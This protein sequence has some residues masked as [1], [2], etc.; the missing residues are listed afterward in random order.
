M[1]AD[2]L[3]TAHALAV[4]APYDYHTKQ[5]WRAKGMA[6]LRR[7]AKDL[8]L[9][10]GTYDLRFN[11]GGGAVSGD[12]ILH[13][14]SLYVHLSG[15]SAGDVGYTRRVKGRKDYFG[16]RNISVPKSYEGLLR[17]ARAITVQVSA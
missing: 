11:P 7:L 1:P 2:A 9:A 16:E 14:D 15:F 10:K 12:A 8:G 4:S 5:A 13:S 6:V 3:C 17:I